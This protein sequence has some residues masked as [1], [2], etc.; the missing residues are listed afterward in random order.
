MNTLPQWAKTLNQLGEKRP[1]CFF[2]INYHG[3][4]GEVFPLSALPK[5][6][7]FS[8]SEE[9]AAV[10]NPILI[11]KHPIPYPIFEKSFQKVFSHLEKGDTALINLTFATEI[12]AVDL[13]K[14]YQNAKAKYKILY[15]DEWVCFSPEIFVKIEA[16]RIKTYPMKGTISATLPDAE[17]LLLNNP[18]EID[19][20][21]KVVALLSTDLA[22]V[23]TDI[24]VSKFRYVDVIE[25]S[26]GNLL[27]TSSEIIG[28]LQS[29]WQA[30]LGEILAKLLPAGSICGT[31]RE[32]T[33]EI[34]REAETYQ[35]G[36]YTGIAGIFDG[37]SLDTCVLIRFIERIGDKFYYKSGAGI[38][39]QSK[40]ESEYKE[41]LEKIYIPN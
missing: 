20:H 34:I 39:A 18:K 10:S 16:D 3:T 1:P 5:D 8:F 33:M 9:K 25:K 13:N 7:L 32:K 37:E 24:H 12:D 11:E 40:P 4:S 41:I 31:P 30:H 17:S 26:T 21:K 35:R 38:T 22:H 2:V 14:V 28:T 23:A 36:Y 29:D 15:K 6:I 27:Q 19:E